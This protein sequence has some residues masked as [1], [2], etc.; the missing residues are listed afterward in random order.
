[1]R[2]AERGFRVTA[3]EKA[4]L[5]NG[6]SSRSSA[7]IRAQFGVPETVVGMAYSEWWYGHFHELLCTPAERAQPVIARNGYL[8]LYEDPEQAAPPWRPALRRDAAGAWTRAQANLA[9]QREFGL[10]VELLEPDAV[11]ARWPHIESERLIGATWCPDDGFLQP[12]MIYGEGFRRAREL[13][14]EV[15]TGVEVMGARHG[16]RG[17][18]AVETT[19]GQIEADWVVNATNAWGPRTSARLGG[20][21]LP[22]SPLKRYLYFLKS[23]RPIMSEEQWQAL[24]MTIYGHGAGRGAVSRPDGPQ[25]LMSWAH[26]ADSE[27]DFSDADQDRI[28]PGFDHAVGIEN[29]GYAVL[30]QIATFAPALADCGGLTATACGYYGTTPDANPLIG[31]DQ[32]QPNLVHAAGCSGHGLMHAPITAVLVEA[33]LA[34]DVCDGQVRLP[35]PFARHMLN[36]A[37]FAPERDFA[38]SHHE[39]MAL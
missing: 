21:P 27:P 34:G 7:C 28:A 2:L 39:T 1:V 8:F 14:V 24:P 38:H 12:H 22:I 13:G 20:M 26:P 9:M 31:F 16:P 15:R 23:Q 19:E 4:A 35:D 5:G 29:F 33:L 37:A 36:L 10:P 17:I 25:L 11:H 18:T 32:R 3:L 6:S 30:E